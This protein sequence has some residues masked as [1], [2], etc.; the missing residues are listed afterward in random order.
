[1]TS[2]ATA[3]LLPT[4]SGTSYLP[5]WVCF[6]AHVI[7]A[8][9]DTD[10][11]DYQAENDMLLRK[12]LLSTYNVGTLEL[13]HAFFMEEGSHFEVESLAPISAE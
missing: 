13:Q 5:T 2:V 4:A 3:C 1:M 6:S 8:S 11:M 9:L 10:K 12:L 7:I